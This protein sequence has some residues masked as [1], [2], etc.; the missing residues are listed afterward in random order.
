MKTRKFIATVLIFLA[1]LTIAMFTNST[2]AADSS[3]GYLTITTDRKEG[4]VIYKHRLYYGTQNVKDI[5][6]IISCDVN[7][8]PSQTPITDLYCLRAGLGF[9]SIN[10]DNKVVEYNL[11][12]DLV[13]QYQEVVNHFKDLDSET[14][15]FDENKK[16]NFDA[17]MWILDNM[18]LEGATDEQ[19]TEYLK[20]YAG[21]DEESLEEAEKQ[22]NILTRSDI[23]AIQQ[24]A[25]WYFTNDDELGEGE[26]HNETLPTLFLYIYGLDRFYDTDTNIQDKEYPYKSLAEIFDGKYVLE[27][28]YGTYRQERAQ[29][30]YENLITNAKEITANGTYKPTR[31][32]TVYLAG[33]EAADEQPVV[34]VEDKKEVDVALRKFI[35]SKNGEALT[36]ENSREPQVNTNNLN[37]YVEGELQTTAEYNHTKRP[38]RTEI[39]DIVTYTLRIYNEGQVDAYITEVTDYLPEYL[40]ISDDNEK[41][42]WVVDEETGRIAKTTE[43]C[44]VVNKGK[45]VNGENITDEE[46]KAKEEKDLLRNVLIPKAEYREATDNYD[47]S[48]VDIEIECKVIP[49]T[50]FNTNVTNIA[51]ITKMEDERHIQLPDDRDSKPDGKKEGQFVIPSDDQLPNYKDTESD[52]PYVPGQEDDDDFEKV[53]VPT[54]EIDLA[55]R[56]FISAVGDTGYDRAPQVDTKG[57][58]Q[59][60]ETAEYNHSKIPVEVNVGDVVTYTIRLYNEGDVAGRVKEVRDILAKNL[61]Y[62]PFGNDSADAEN[63]WWTETESEEYN[64]LRSTDKCIVVNKGK[65]VNGQNIVD[66]EYKAKAEKDLLG[67]VTIPAYDKEKDE[68]SYIDVEVHCQVL[69]VEKTIK[70]TNIAEITKE[71]DEYG[72]EVPEDRDSKPEGKKDGEFEIPDDENLPSYK[73]TESDKPYVPGQ[74]DDDD[75]EKVIVKVP[76]IDLSLRKYISE[77]DGEALE[78]S[79]E[80]VVNTSPIDENKDTTS[81][82]DHSKKPVQVKKG[83]LVTYTIRVYNEGELDGYASEITDYLPAYLIYLPEN[84][85]NQKYGWVYNE[86]TREVRTTITAKDNVNG[87]EVYKDRENGKLILKYDGEGNLDYIDVKIVCKIDEKAVGNGILTNLAQITKETDKEGKDIPKDKDSKPNDNFELPKDED[88]PNYKDDE[89]DKPFVPGQ[90]DDDD[91]EKVVV[92]P[93]FDLALRKFI[94]KVENM[95]VNNRYPSVSYDEENGKLTYEHPKNALEVVTG[96]VVTYTI[97][98]YNEGEADGY[99]NEITDDVPEGLEFLPD[100]ETNK[101]YRWVMLDENEEETTDVSKAKYI[102]SDYLSEEQQTETGRDNLLK[103]FNKEAGVTDTNPDFR[104]VKIAFKV[105]FQSK[106]KEDTTKKIVNTAQISKDS[107]DDIDSEPKRDEVYNHDDDKDNEDD[108]DYDNVRVQYFDLSLLKW[109]SHTIVTLNG[110]TTET[111][112]GHTVENAKDEDPVKLEIQSKDIKKINIKYRYTI[113]ITNEGEIA[114][115]AT[116]ITDYIP[117]GLKFVKEDNPDWYEK[118]DGTIG[119]RKLENTLLQPGEYAEVEVIL[120]WINGTENFGK[121]VNL[122]EISEDKNE[123]GVPDIDSTPNN[124]KDEEDDIDD[125]PVLLAVKTG[126]TQIYV[127]LVMIILVTFA[128]G[129]SLIKKYVLE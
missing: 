71:T 129:I 78:N 105:T 72:N 94:T 117:E 5:W 90:E 69:P 82:Y 33:A 43:A 26:F 96:D 83:S 13:K 76:E 81:E 66:E 111:P 25:I 47:L 45:V 87:D 122:A 52:K 84:E 102:V 55:L 31:S 22:E 121:K 99:A 58:K 24:L 110:K 93:D 67:D 120:T 124:K 80:P 108:I 92:K 104:D 98:I 12:Y 75:F 44:I 57:L 30:L 125:A 41:G 10:L 38:L 36:G 54:P 21:Y 4:D 89:S 9:T 11:S 113:R 73:D 46:Y 40:V 60:A 51:Q 34:K 109:V 7:G 56:K 100:D 118:E 39:G 37:K 114:G 79:R 115:Y 61:K 14:T 95:D 77:V 15:I 42:W 3:L 49:T 1:V 119:T 48:Y 27:S 70:L 126:E 29:E 19:V 23:E 53:F 28:T 62:V 50:P 106:T 86:E 17:V 35:S 32:I 65:V 103:A 63:G 127:G 101:T 18:L 97:R 59:G 107:D 128:G 6:K 116:E 91:F 123:K 68:L 85:T 20:T 64:V 74:E 2:K 88:R 112:T 8:V 16:A